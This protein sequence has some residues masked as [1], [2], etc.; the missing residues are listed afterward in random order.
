M[1]AC[2]LVEAVLLAVDHLVQLFLRLQVELTLLH[3][4]ISGLQRDKYEH[5]ELLKPRFET[6]IS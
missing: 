1:W 4:S 5:T 2:G 6:D 3:V